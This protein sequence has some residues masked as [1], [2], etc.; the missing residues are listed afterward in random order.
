MYKGWKEVQKMVVRPYGHLPDLYVQTKGGRWTWSTAHANRPM[1]PAHHTQDVKHPHWL[2]PRRQK[3]VPYRV[4]ESI[5]DL[6]PNRAVEFHWYWAAEILPLYPRY[7]EPPELT[8]T[9]T[10]LRLVFWVPNPSPM[11]TRPGVSRWSR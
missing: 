3:L 9:F 11:T 8:N 5:T 2:E 10:R 6:K 4:L 1:S 7:R